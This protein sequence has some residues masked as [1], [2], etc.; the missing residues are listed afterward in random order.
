[1]MAARAMYK[2]GNVIGLSSNLIAGNGMDLFGVGD[3][4]AGQQQMSYQLRDIKNQ[5]MD[6]DLSEFDS[7]I[8]GMVRRQPRISSDLRQCCPAFL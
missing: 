5:A 7:A 6:N 3:A 1:M 4:D 8:I 2:L